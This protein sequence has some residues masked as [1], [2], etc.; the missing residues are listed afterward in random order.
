MKYG[1]TSLEHTDSIGCLLVRKL[2]TWLADYTPNSA[3]AQR[4]SNTV[5]QLSNRQTKIERLLLIPGAPYSNRQPEQRNALAESVFHHCK[6]RA[7]LPGGK[8]PGESVPAFLLTQPHNSATIRSHQWPGLST[9]QVLV[10]CMRPGPSISP[11]A[12][13]ISHPD[14]TA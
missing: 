12:S 5:H 4:R 2:R 8:S 3:G 11:R 10:L 9:Y 6:K 13:L 7:S 1:D 14:C